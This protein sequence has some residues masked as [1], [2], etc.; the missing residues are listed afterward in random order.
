MDWSRALFQII[1]LQ[2]F[3]SL[4]YWIV[5]AVTWSS[6]SHFVLGIPYDLISRARRKGGQAEQDLVDLVRINVNRLLQIAQSAGLVLMGTVCFALSISL[7]IHFP[8]CVSGCRRP[9]R[10]GN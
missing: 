5:V 1:D 3:S 7:W 10:R 9:R 2:S 4:W 6:V 8:P